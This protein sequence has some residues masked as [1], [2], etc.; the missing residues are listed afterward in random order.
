MQISALNFTYFMT[1][2][3]VLQVGQCYDAH[4]YKATKPGMGSI[5]P[6]PAALYVAALAANID[7]FRGP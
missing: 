4:A 7:R 5:Y 6:M 3:Y 1:A 2:C